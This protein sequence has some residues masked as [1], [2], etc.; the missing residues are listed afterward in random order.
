MLNFNK[1]IAERLMLSF[2]SLYYHFTIQLQ[3]KQNRLLSSSK[4]L[5]QHAKVHVASK[6]IREFVC[7][8][9]NC[10]YIGQTASEVQTHLLTHHHHHQLTDERNFMCT[11][12]G[13]DYRGKTIT[14]LRR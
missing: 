3:I 1:M 9:E 11:E 7:Q 2:N 6:S 8:H 5:S 13:C 12:Q 10:F 4:I 14:Q